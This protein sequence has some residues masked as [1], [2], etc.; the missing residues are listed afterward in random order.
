[1]NEI[2]HDDLLTIYVDGDACP[3]KDEVFR[4][5]APRHQVL[6]R[7]VCNSWLRLPAS[8]LI[9]QCIVSEG[10][11]A[12]DD[13][14][15]EHVSVGDIVVTADIQLAARCLKKTDEGAAPEW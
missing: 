2:W 5:A 14:I 13:W 9:E 6:T 8:P 10:F 4:V 3:V 11:D 7:I 15:I 1:M 12:A